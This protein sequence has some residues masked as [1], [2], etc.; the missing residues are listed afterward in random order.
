MNQKRREE[1]TAAPLV[2]TRKPREDGPALLVTVEA[3]VV[4]D[5]HDGQ[6]VHH[7]PPSLAANMVTRDGETVR[8][9]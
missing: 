1:N 6:A 9:V 4:A 8:W 7:D 3:V 2:A 5:H